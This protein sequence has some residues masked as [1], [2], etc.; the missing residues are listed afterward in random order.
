[1]RIIDSIP[2]ILQIAFYVCLLF[3]PAVLLAASLRLPSINR[4]TRRSP[5]MRGL[6]V[7]GSG[8]VCLG[9]TYLL[10]TRA[11]TVLAYDIGS[12]YFYQ[13]LD[14]AAG[15]THANAVLLKWT[16]I[17]E[18]WFRQIIPGGQTC[19]SGT[20]VVCQLADGVSKIA[21]FGGSWFVFLGVALV[22]TLFNL[23]MGWKYTRASD[24]LKAGQAVGQP[25]PDSKQ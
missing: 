16:V 24:G 1:M 21:S 12:Y 18:M 2:A 3:L 4:L 10:L 23:S 9:I 14:P 6:V 5:S 22:P 8:L 25:S 7:L 19:F 15:I 17:N 13:T 11:A 20:A